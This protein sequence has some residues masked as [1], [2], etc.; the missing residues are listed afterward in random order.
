ML[1]KSL[2]QRSLQQRSLQQRSLQQRSLQVHSLQVHSLQQCT[3]PNHYA[4]ELSRDT[5]GEG[6]GEEEGGR[7]EGE[8]ERG[9]G[10]RSKGRGHK[11]VTGTRLYHAHA[12]IF[13]VQ[14]I[15]A[16][17]DPANDLAGPRTGAVITKDLQV[18]V[19]RG[20]ACQGVCPGEK[21]VLLLA[22][23]PS[24]Q[25]SPKACS[26]N[27]VLQWRRGGG[28]ERGRGGEGRRGEGRGGYLCIPQYART[29]THNADTSGEWNDSLQ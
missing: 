18:E 10:R 11:E 24:R 1:V 28:G 14:C 6:R 25:R 19:W 29:Y 2:Q 16:A 5:R 21:A 9:G 12:H 4:L 26:G 8:E 17:L 3:H 7:G 20:G 27:T 13:L 23:P 15:E 22:H